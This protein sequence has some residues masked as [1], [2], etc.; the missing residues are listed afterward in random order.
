MKYINK[1]LTIE[2]INL[3]K[4]ANKFEEKKNQLMMEDEAKLGE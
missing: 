1:T 2:K 4:I 3:Q